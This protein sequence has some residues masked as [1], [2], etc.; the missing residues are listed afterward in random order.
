MSITIRKVPSLQL[1]QYTEHLLRLSPVDRQLR[2]GN[3][4]S[5]EAIKRYV[6]TQYR[7]KQIVLGAYDDQNS[8]VAAIE[9]VFDTTKYMPINEFAE[10]GLSVQEG[11]RGDGLG[12]ELFKRAVVIAQNRHVTKLVSHCLTRNRWMM[13]IAKN[14]GMT[15][16]SDSGDS[17]GTVDLAP[18]NLI[19]VMG[20]AIGDGIS[21]LDYARMPIGSLFNPAFVQKQT[22][23]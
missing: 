9:I 2:F 13:R 6:D 7:I 1:Y 14:N 17:M 4:M 20:E 8:I 12:T 19:S 23:Q 15:V 11:H 5:D 22:Q 10:L 16:E 18:G 21:L 3:A